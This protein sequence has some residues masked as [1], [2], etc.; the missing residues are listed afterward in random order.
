MMRVLSAF[1]AQTAARL[2][3]DPNRSRRAATSSVT[4]HDSEPW[5]SR[6]AAESGVPAPQF[7]STTRTRL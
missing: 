1:S 4:D 3:S 6:T 5:Q 2:V 7:G